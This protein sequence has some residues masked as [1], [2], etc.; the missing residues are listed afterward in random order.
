MSRPQ[1][2]LWA[3]TIILPNECMA[4]SITTPLLWQLLF[5]NLVFKD[6]C[7]SKALQRA[8]VQE[9]VVG[10]TPFQDLLKQQQ[11]ALT[12]V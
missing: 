7:K 9:F 6:G 8:R 11:V 3:K 5:G 1:D 12:V 10:C 2:L 4:C